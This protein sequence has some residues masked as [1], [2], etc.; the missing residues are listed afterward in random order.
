MKSK[1]LTCLYQTD[2]EKFKYKEMNKILKLF[3]RLYYTPKQMG[4]HLNQIARS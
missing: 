4:K 1:N 3:K 2:M